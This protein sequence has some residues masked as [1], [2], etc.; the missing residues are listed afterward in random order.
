MGTPVRDMKRVLY[1]CEDI[2]YRFMYYSDKI[3]TPARTLVPYSD[4]LLIINIQSCG[5]FL[6][7]SCIKALKESLEEILVNYISASLYI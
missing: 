6:Q 4:H 5:V 3:I 2:L 7:I 1:G